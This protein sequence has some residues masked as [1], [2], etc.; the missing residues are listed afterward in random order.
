MASGATCPM[1][2]PWLKPGE[3]PVRNQGN[4][5]L[6]TFGDEPICHLHQLVHAGGTLGT[7]V[8][9]YDYVSR[10]DFVPHHRLRSQF[11]LI[12][13]PRPSREGTHALRYASGAADRALFRQISPENPHAGNIA[14]GGLQGMNDTVVW[15]LDSSEI[16][17]PGISKQ[18]CFP[19]I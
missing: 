11:L 9:Q 19:G 7:L 3:A 18:C 14:E 8:A 2:V 6:H 17:A 15:D 5:L 4:R 10:L 12:K 16:L 1:M 13:D